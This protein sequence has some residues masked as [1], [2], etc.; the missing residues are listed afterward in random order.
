MKSRMQAGGL[1]REQGLTG[2][3]DIEELLSCAAAV[4]GVRRQLCNACCFDAEA[5]VVPLTKD[6]LMGQLVLLQGIREHRPL[7]GQSTPELG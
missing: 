5:I 7:L 6:P 3:H 4:S 2:A 1:G